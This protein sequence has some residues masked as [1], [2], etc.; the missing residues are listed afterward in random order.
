VTHSNNSHRG[1]Q[2][3]QAAHHDSPQL[4]EERRRKL[5]FALE[6]LRD[7]DLLR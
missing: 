5:Q 3:T 6:D 7:L 4:M 1:I 2:H